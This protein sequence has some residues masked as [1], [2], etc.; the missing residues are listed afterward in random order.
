MPEQQQPEQ[1]PVRRRRGSGGW[2][3]VAVLGL[4]ALLVA[5]RDASRR[6]TATA[7]AAPPSTVTA[8]GYPPISTSSPLSATAGSTWAIRSVDTMKLSRDTL[9]APLSDRQIAEVVRQDARLRLTH[10]AVDV[11]YDNPS[12]MERWVRAVRASGLHVWFRA[13]WYRWENHRDLRGDMSPRAYIDDTR[14]FLQQ[15]IDLFASGDIFDFCAEPENGAYW[16]QTYGQGWSWRSNKAAKRA[17]NTFIRSGVYM[18]GTTLAHRGRGD[19]LVTAIS[20]DSSVAERLLSKP[21]VQRLG[22]ITLDLYPEGKTR[23]P[24]TAARLFVAE[25]EKVHRKW[26][27]PILIGE[28]GYARDIAVDD[29]TQARVLHSELAALRRLPYVRGLNYWVDAGGPGYGG[30]TNLQRKVHGHWQPRPAAAVLANAF[31]NGKG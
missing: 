23:D 2:P 22:L 21:T 3:L 18:A 20:V 10:V 4:L 17:F 24:A 19:V 28:H 26:P 27:V 8:G 1:Q 29:A 11:F 16:V 14:E 25:I 15:Y 9:K 6:A 31:G 12:Y 30:Y 7:A 13:H 5:V